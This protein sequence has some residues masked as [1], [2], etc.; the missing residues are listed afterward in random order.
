MRA[1]ISALVLK[2]GEAFYGAAVTDFPPLDASFV[3]FVLRTRL[4]SLRPEALPP[5]AD[6]FKAFQLVGHRPEDF[7]LILQRAITSGKPSGE[8]LVEYA[9]RRRAEM[10]NE[11]KRQLAVLTPLQRAVL[12]RMADEDAQFAPFTAETL[13]FYAK[14][15]GKLLPRKKITTGDVQRA[16]DSLERK[17]RLVWRSARGAYALDDHMI[18]DV[19]N[20][21]RIG[22]EMR[23]LTE[24][25][26]EELSVEEL[27]E[28]GFFGDVT[29]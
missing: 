7:D 25:G 19:L 26:T 13:A 1:K 5:K 2:K 20:K 6:A 22:E 29:R 15:C 8:A 21:E 18:G 24:P 17:H 3:E 12:R 28:H 9:V 27:T 11:L 10:F 4:A 16:L 23:L 14:Y